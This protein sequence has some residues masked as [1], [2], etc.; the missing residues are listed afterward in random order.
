ML[1]IKWIGIK[2]KWYKNGMIWR[3]DYIENEMIFKWDDFEIITYNYEIWS[4]SVNEIK[5]FI[6]NLK[7]RWAQH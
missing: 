5:Y 2:M 4:C 1:K 7:V 6:S 3:W